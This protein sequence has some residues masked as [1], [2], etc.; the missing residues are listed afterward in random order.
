M[1]REIVSS[2]S[3]EERRGPEFEHYTVLADIL[4]TQ[5]KVKMRKLEILSLM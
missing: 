4:G 3:R 1:R 2:T 5:N